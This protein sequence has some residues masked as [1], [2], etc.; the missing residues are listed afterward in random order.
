MNF[1]ANSAKKILSADSRRSSKQSTVSL[2]S[3]YAVSE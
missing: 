3:L 2:H 1:C